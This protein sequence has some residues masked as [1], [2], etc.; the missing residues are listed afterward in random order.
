MGCFFRKKSMKH[1][2][3]NLLRE[4]DSVLFQYENSVVRFEEPDSREEANS[5]LDYIVKD[6]FGKIIV[7]PSKR[8]IKRIKLRWRG[9]LSDVISVLGDAL[10]VNC[11]YS[12]GFDL[13][14]CWHSIIPERKMPW[15]FHTFDG[16]RLNC[17]GVKTGPDAIC[18]FQCDECG[19]TL[20]LDLRNFSGGVSL[21]EPLLAAEVV[22]RE[23]ELGE[24]PFYAAH[25]FCK[26]MCEN[27][28]LPKT[29]IFGVNNWYWA[30]GNISHDSIMDECDQLMD[31]CA[32]AVCKPY[33]IIDDGWQKNRFKNEYEKVYN[34][35]PWAL[36]STAFPSMRET[37]R[38][39]R[40]KGAVPGLWF[41]PLLTYGDLPAGFASPFQ[42]H[43]IGTFLDPTNPDVL[44][45]IFNDVKNMVDAGFGL[46]KHDFTT[47][48]TIGKFGELVDGDQHFYDNSVTNATMMK[49][50]YK[51]V[52]A[53]AG[54][55]EVTGCNTANHLV[56]GIHS[57]QRASRDTSGNLYEITR[58]AAA[59]SFIRLP[60]NKAFFSLDPDCAPITERVP[61]EINLDFLELCANA[62]VV[63]LGSIKPG[64]IKGK[65]LTRIRNIYKTASLG[66]NDAIPDRWVCNN[67]PSKFTSNDGK[68][69]S[70]NWYNVYDGVRTFTTWKD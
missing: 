21:K 61:I 22:C 12:Y 59:S 27:P 64:I 29:P 52:Q 5:R 63:T 20:W 57:S 54:D 8:P 1:S 26:M 28:V 38:L 41:R 67:A 33:M 10:D 58:I 66:G 43:P 14:A 40:E 25:T 65:H 3:I 7:F 11:S 56:A 70:C 9:D 42:T 31:M 51:T 13:F 69:L 6:G 48:D 35:G 24:N 39:I 47:L 17:F 4:P 34:G 45:K 68:K 15:Y 50:I 23:G 37:A 30:Y 44:S 60:Q 18:Y 46:I 62:G 2:F 19:I 36:S 53:A 32:D 55:A 49:R 16:E